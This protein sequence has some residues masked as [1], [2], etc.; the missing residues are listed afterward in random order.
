MCDFCYR[1][2]YVYKIYFN[3]NKI[4]LSFLC[5]DCYKKY[6][7]L[8]LDYNL[9]RCSN[10]YCFECNKKVWDNE[11]H[12]LNKIIN[13]VSFFNEVDCRNNEKYNRHTLCENCFNLKGGE[14]F[15]NQLI[16]F[17]IKLDK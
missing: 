8:K 9:T 12:A 14:E 4:S 7:N 10:V 15:L 3:F 16:K 13:Y 1:P 17:K 11:H 2:T 6:I 5:S